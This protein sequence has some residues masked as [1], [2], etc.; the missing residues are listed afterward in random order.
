MDTP[1]A[2]I[3]GA[4]RGIGRAIAL[5]LAS[6]GYTVLVNYHENGEAAVAVRELIV[7][8]G[9][10]AVVRQFDVANQPEVEEAVKE[11]THTVGPIQVLVNNAGII[12]DHLLM[13]M[14]DQDW[15]KVIDTDLHGVYYCTKAIVRTM[16]GKRRPGRS[17]VNITS[18][19]E[20]GHTGQANYAAAK[21]GIIGFTKAL[22]RELGPLGI[23]VNAV[24][25]GPIDTDAIQ[26]LQLDA[27]VKKN[28]PGT[29][30]TTGR[31]GF[32]GFLPRIP[33]G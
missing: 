2:L 22:A 8:K 25:P 24:A 30:W 10:A 13:R 11:L 28:S 3:T 31:G 15:H 16:A 17:I 1:I 21:A 19:G 9:G 32:S 4:S 6:D 5:Q 7:S 26:H 29:D 23:T 20:M 27:L 33:A 18:G 14:P 12:R